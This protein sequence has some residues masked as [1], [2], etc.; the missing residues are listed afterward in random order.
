MTSLA[1]AVAGLLAGCLL[2]RR[3]RGSLLRL[4]QSRL[5]RAWDAECEAV[6]ALSDAG[7]EHA[8][9]RAELERAMATVA[10][11]TKQVGEL[12]AEIEG[13]YHDYDSLLLDPELYIECREA[14]LDTCGP[15]PPLVPELNEFIPCEN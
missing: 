2:M 12:D 14:Y 5:G 6:L 11:L 9:C 3:S 8:R 4:Y 13:V 15:R 7:A 10:A 1:Y